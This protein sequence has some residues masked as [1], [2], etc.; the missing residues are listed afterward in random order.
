MLPDNRMK[1]LEK[2]LRI[3]D[4]WRVQ[5]WLRD[6]KVADMCELTKSGTLQTEGVRNSD[7][8]KARKGKSW[9][10]VENFREKGVQTDPA[11]VKV[12]V[13]NLEKEKGESNGYHEYSTMSQRK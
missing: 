11:K 7:K 5:S 2:T 4:R 13:G 6:Q 3:Q 10:M 8:S 1:M 12:I 9:K